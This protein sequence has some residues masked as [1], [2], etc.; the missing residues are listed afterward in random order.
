ML[1][2]RAPVK[3]G[4]KRGEFIVTKL[5]GDPFLSFKLKSAYNAPPIFTEFYI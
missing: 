1:I 3:G 2:C 5:K 4:V